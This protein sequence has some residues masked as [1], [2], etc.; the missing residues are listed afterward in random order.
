MASGNAWRTRRRGLANSRQPVAMRIVVSA[1]LTPQQMKISA[2]L[3]HVMRDLLAQGLDGRKLDLIAHAVEKTDLDFALRSQVNRMEVQ[4]VRL[5]GKRL[6]AERR[7]IANIGHGLK[8]LA[9]NA[10][11]CDVN[12]VFGNKLLVASQVDGRYGIF[13]AIAASA[14]GRPQNTERARQ[15]MPRPPHA[16]L[17]A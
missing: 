1:S 14:S 4:Q 11:P 9:S 3:L 10:R 13:R 6:R 8:A 7:T 16:P 5:D 15:Q 17:T 12:A 2:R